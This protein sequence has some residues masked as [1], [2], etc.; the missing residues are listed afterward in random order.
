[1]IALD[2]PRHFRLRSLVSKGFTPKEVAR[3]ETYVKEKAAGVIDRLLEE[4]PDG[5]ADFVQAVAAPLPL[6]I[7]CE[8]MGLDPEQ[9]L[10]MYGWSDAM[11]AGD[12]HVEPE[13]SLGRPGH[14]HLHVFGVRDAGQGGRAAGRPGGVRLRDGHGHP[15]ARRGT[16]HDHARS[17][18]RAVYRRLL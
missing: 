12:G 8:M 10:S 3:V 5:T 11:M 13:R 16:D 9:R 6:E 1:M 4:H 18:R 17:H 7:I 2:D 15:D 14:R